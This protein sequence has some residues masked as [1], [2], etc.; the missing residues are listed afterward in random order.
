MNAIKTK[1]NLDFEA[2]PWERLGSIDESY[3][4]FRIGTCAGLW[5][6]VDDAYEIL[7]V[8][9]DNPGNGHFDDVLQWFEFAAKRDGKALR[10]MEVWNK[11][12]K[13]HLIKKRGFSPYQHDHVIKRKFTL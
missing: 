1:H 9:N 12:L 8:T 7:A 5:R 6:C 13:Q 3:I 2:A 10:V 4:K 11:K